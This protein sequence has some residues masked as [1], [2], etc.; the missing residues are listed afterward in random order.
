[1]SDAQTIRVLDIWALID[2]PDD[3]PPIH[4]DHLI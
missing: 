4:S 2:A 3:A 1:M